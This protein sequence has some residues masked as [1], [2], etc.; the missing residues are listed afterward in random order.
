MGQSAYANPFGSA[1]SSHGGNDYG[2]PSFGTGIQATNAPEGITLNT[3]GI[4]AAALEEARELL[5]LGR[6]LS[7][8]TGHD[9][10]VD[11]S[12]TTGIGSADLAMQLAS[13]YTDAY[14]DGMNPLE[15]A[16]CPVAFSSQAMDAARDLFTYAGILGD[17]NPANGV[18]GNHNGKNIHN[19]KLGVLDDMGWA[20]Q[21]DV[22]AFDIF[23][24][25]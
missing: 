6:G 24:S 23:N 13:C 25:K 3:V 8:E 21:S 22:D 18:Q 19:A 15:L 12:I 1:S 17:N 14:A 11:P 4:L 2:N 20:S 10:N 9:L 16:S 7:K 5:S